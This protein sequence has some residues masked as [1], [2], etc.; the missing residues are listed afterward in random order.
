MK[1]N[2]YLMWEED[3]GSFTTRIMPVYAFEDMYKLGRFVSYLMKHGTLD[4]AEPVRIDASFQRYMLDKELSCIPY[5]VWKSIFALYGLQE[6][7]PYKS[8]AAQLGENVLDILLPN[9]ISQL[10]SRYEFECS[11]YGISDEAQNQQ[12]YSAFLS[13]FFSE[14]AGKPEVEI[15]SRLDNKKALSIVKEWMTWNNESFAIYPTVGQISVITNR[16]RATELWRVDIHNGKVEQF[17]WDSRVTSYCSANVESLATMYWMY[18]DMQAV[19]SDF[20]VPPLK[21]VFCRKQS[22]SS[23]S[24]IN[25]ICGYNEQQ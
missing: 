18:D 10:C 19:L 23:S 25:Y 4:R 7:S 20:Y 14:V 3:S 15:D 22:Y 21:G 8:C 1:H 16:L 5:K 6:P 12:N 17:L 2:I 13:S 11:D 24:F 9:S